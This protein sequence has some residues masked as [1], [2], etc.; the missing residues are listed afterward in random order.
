M[1][2]PNE[3][4][5]V[6]CFGDSI[7]GPLPHLD[8]QPEYLKWSDL[9]ELMLETRRGRGQV[10]VLNRGFSGDKTFAE[11]GLEH[12][13]PGALSRLKRE[14]VEE[15]PDVAIV[16]IGGNDRPVTPDERERTRG[17]LCAMFGRLKR[18]QIPTLALTYACL[19][20]PQAPRTAWRELLLVNPLIESVTQALDIPVLALQPAFD[21]AACT[22]SAPDL[23]SEVD[24]VHLKPL[25]EIVI[26]R[27]VFWELARLHWI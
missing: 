14:V 8:Y 24:G 15:E 26:A 4:F 22:R 25:G 3:K 6:V 12:P 10:Q 5:K 16:L 21:D 9:L 18:A 19:P 7:T 17:N 27:A 13:T 23:V 11:P 1:T 20:N 2:A